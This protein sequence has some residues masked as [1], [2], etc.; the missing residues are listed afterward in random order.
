MTEKQ[1][2]TIADGFKI[3]AIRD[4]GKIM[5]SRQV[6]DVLNELNNENERLKFE[7]DQLKNVPTK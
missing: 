2:F 4:N 5:N 7:I 3:V 6:C 1:R